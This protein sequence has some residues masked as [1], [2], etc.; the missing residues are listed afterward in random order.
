MQPM[1]FIQS[2]YVHC[3]LLNLVILFRT[4]HVP[5]LLHCYL[6]RLESVQ[7][8]EELSDVYTHFMLY[9]GR[10]LIVMKNKTKQPDTSI[11]ETTINTVHKQAKR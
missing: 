2:S 4:K 3:V 9:Y 11:E 1:M 5:K 8:E 6:F 10:D 7:T